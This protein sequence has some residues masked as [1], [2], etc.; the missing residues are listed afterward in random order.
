MANEKTI[1]VVMTRKC[2]HDGEGGK[3]LAEAGGDVLIHALPKSLADTFI[4]AE[5]ARAPTAKERKTAD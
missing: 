3:Y 1:D 5:V 2:V 4:E